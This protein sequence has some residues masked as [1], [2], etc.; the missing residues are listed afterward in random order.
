MIIERIA[1]QI[2]HRLRGLLRRGAVEREMEDELAL[3]LE[4]EADA[5]VRRGMSP[6]AARRQAVLALGG[7]EG[8]KEAVRDS[9]G[10][11]PLEDLV[12]DVRFA[13]RSFARTPGFTLT[14]VLVLALGIGATTAIFSAVRAVVL[15]P[16]PFAEPQRLYT[17]WESSPETG[18]EGQMVSPANYLD[19]KERV[20]SFA[21][22]EAYGSPWQAPITG[23]DQPVALR[24]L[25]VTGGLFS[26]LG[27]RPMLGRGFTEAE[28]WA[29]ATWRAGETPL[30]LSADT[31]RNVFGGDASVIG[32]SVTLNGG[33]ARVVGVMPEGFAFPE[34]G[35]QLWVPFGWADEARGAAWFRRSHSVW[36]VA[37][38][39][40]GATPDRAA[41]ELH[42]V[43]AQLERE[44][45]ETNRPGGAG[46]SP[47]H[48]FLL[49]DTRTPLLVLLA[50][51]G[52]LLLI[53]CANVG[54]LLLVRASAHRRSLAVRAALGAGRGRLVRQTLTESVVLAALGGGA[55]IALGIAGTRLLERLQPA[56]LLRTTSFPV[57][58]AVIA[59][60][61]ATA[62]GAAIVFGTFPAFVARRAGP[63]EALREAGRSGGP[64]RLARRV[65]GGLVVAEVALAALLVLGAGLL[66]RSI[67]ELRRVDPGFNPEGVVAITLKVPG[68]R[69][70]GPAQVTAFYE[71][72]LARVRMLPGVASAAASSTLPLRDRG[73]TSDFFIAGRAADEFG[74]EVLRRSVTPG[75]LATMGVPLLAGRGFTEADAWRGDGADGVVLINEAMAR[76]HFPGRD[77]V[78]QRITLDR[79]PDSASAWHT[80]VG[81]VGSERQSVIATPAQIEII[82]P[83]AQNPERE[84]YIYVRVARG[85]PT[86]LVPA[87]GSILRDLDPHLPLFGATAMEDLVAD[88]MAR[89]RFLMRLL[90]TFAA[91]AVVLA[92][93]GVY[94]VT[95]QAARQRMP[96]LGLRMALGARHRDIVWLTV[97]HGLALVALGVAMGTAGALAATRAMTGMLYG[98]TPNDPPTF[99]VVAVFLTTAGLAAS[100][101]PAR[102]AAR[103]D[104]AHTLR[105]E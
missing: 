80:I 28:S 60:A 58:G 70:R 48:D 104:P 42:A 40:D 66:V 13:F 88:S 7:V 86:R 53:S 68:A 50:A 79:S 102:R 62:A 59:F 71:E 91:V 4:M 15:R 90:L 72:V 87:V 65:V 73:S 92:L 83:F 2:R 64:G 89:D 19:W 1:S 30:L 84:M 103:V 69:Y 41:A 100:W 26:M 9:R 85:D 77:P 57:D 76:Q 98:I 52:L 78:G 47:L 54:N 11:R 46:M 5:N 10:V 93:V 24:T 96:E 39:A 38:L 43:A 27:V 95:A 45:P 8:T 56:G 81:V 61:V 74:T 101:L 82:E 22:V 18:G 25:P 3:H 35:V 23:L 17:L 21:D 75:Y 33:P 31:W 34:E 67:T 16:L 12:R 105:A 51:V 36:P 63:G 6:E 97:R 44:H 20:A 37:R 29:G 99:A 49:G 32:A 14:A 94:G 55:G